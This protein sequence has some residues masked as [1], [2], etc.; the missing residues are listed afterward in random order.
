MCL[1][2]HAALESLR[3]GA[4]G[5]FMARAAPLVAMVRNCVR[6][7]A[8]EPALVLVVLW[9][10]SIHPLSPAASEHRRL[11]LRGELSISAAHHVVLVHKLASVRVLGLVLLVAQ[12]TRLN[13]LPR[14]AMLVYRRPGVHGAPSVHAVCPA[15]REHG[16]G[17]ASVLEA[18][19]E[20]VFATP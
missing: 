11:G 8:P 19:L 2:S 15:G 7:R 5:E 18:V 20:L 1:P 9:V 3:P 16:I 12:W 17:L 14:L 6:E 10:Q 4:L 13:H